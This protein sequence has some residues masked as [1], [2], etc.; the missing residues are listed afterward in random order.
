MPVANA[1]A[2]SGG[3]WTPS[4]LADLLEQYRSG[5]KDRSRNLRGVRWIGEDLAGIDFS[6]CDLTGADLS[7]SDLTNA[8]FCSAQMTS[9]ILHEAKLDG[10]EFLGADLTGANLNGCSAT[11]AGFA[12]ATLANATLLGANCTGASFT[13]SNLEDADLRRADLSTAR[14]VEARLT[15]AQLMGTV[16]AGANFEGCFVGGADF[17]MAKLNGAKLRAL[18][19]FQDAIWIE[20]HIVQVDFA[21]GYRLRRFIMDQNYLH[22]FRSQGRLHEIAYG[23]WW[24]TS[25]CGR[26]LGRWA[27]FTVLLALFYGLIYSGLHLD[28]GPHPT[29]LSPFYYSFVVL[30]SLGFGDVTPATAIAQVVTVSESLVGYLLLGGLISILSTKMARRAE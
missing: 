14:L 22:E 10:T 3:E 16:A 24:L 12:G 1:A 6:G 27:A 30:T 29:A 11:R 2:S 17:S 7:R 26:S 20:T 4:R 18:V 9:V 13:K 28:L 15:G 25:D 5:S 8:R 19:G 23:F 21:G